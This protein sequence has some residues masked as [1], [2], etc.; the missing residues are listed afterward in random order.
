M[1][2]AQE[3]AVA[4]SNELAKRLAPAKLA[5]LQSNADQIAL[6]LKRNNLEWTADNLEAAVWALDMKGLILW[7]IDPVAPSSPKP[8]DLIKQGVEMDAKQRKKHF[9]A[10]H[11]IQH[12]TA[13]EERR[14]RELVDAEQK[15]RVGAQAEIY[16]IINNYL[17]GHGGGGIDYS[18]TESGRKTLRAIK[19]KDTKGHYCPILTLAKVK[20]VWRTLP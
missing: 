19:V 11:R 4:V 10:T 12:N 13:D 5:N 15:K 18:L 20:E 16:R 2:T 14:Q 7:E 9:E 17:V 3:I 6:Y 1:A 8:Q